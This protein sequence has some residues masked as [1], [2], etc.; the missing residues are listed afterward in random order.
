MTTFGEFI[1]RTL[2][3]WLEPADDQPVRFV[4]SQTIDADDATSISFDASLVGP[5]VLELLAAGTLIEVDSE[6]MIVGDVNESAGTIDLAERGANGTTPA[7][8]TSGAFMYPQRLWRRRVVGDAL[9]DAV[10]RLYPDLFRT[11]ISAAISVSSTTYTEIPQAVV[12]D[13]IVAARYFLGTSNGSGDYDEFGVEYRNT[14]PF[15]TSGKAIKVLGLGNGST[16]YLAYKAKYLRPTLEAD[17][18]TDDFG[19]AHE[20]EPI[21]M[22][23]AVAYLIAGRELDLVTQERLSQQLEQQNYPAGAPSSIRDSLLRYRQNLMQ[24]AKDALRVEVP[25]SVTTNGSL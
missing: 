11:P 19:V 6:E 21:A 13:G 1:D 2:R 9:A 24:R 5:E 14:A 18:L 16:G 12:D 7:S 22:L 23:D 10:V 15:V 25:V 4:L 17:D 3:D 20:Y 8:H